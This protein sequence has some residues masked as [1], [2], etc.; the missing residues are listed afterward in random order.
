[1]LA[2]ELDAGDEVVVAAFGR[3]DAA[4]AVELCGARAAFADVRG[5]TYTVDPASV[6]AHVSSRTKAIVPTHLFGVSADVRPIAGLA[7]ARG[8][9]VVEDALDAF[10]ANDKGQRVGTFGD[11]A[12]FSLGPGTG[13]VVTN[14]PHLSV[15]L[16]SLRD[17][18]MEI[19]DARMQIT[20]PGMDARMTALHAAAAQALLSHASD[21]ADARIR[22]AKRYTE[23]L[24]RVPGVEPPSKPGGLRHVY[25]SYV[26]RV[27]G[28]QTRDKLIVDLWGEGVETAAAGRAI[29][30]EPY[31]RERYGLGEDDCPVAVQLARDALALP[32]WPGMDD[33][34]Q[35]AVCDA[36][37]R[38]H[39]C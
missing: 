27:A 31:Y 20:R 19:V 24:R 7:Q 26:V 18:G 10:G 21:A 3:P 25:E 17:H 23:H 16:R 38:C 28:D 37:E 30:V 2:L 39:A 34:T 6:E 13:F 32:L 22:L 35:D 29:H 33:A 11:M 12:C 1:M 15:R 5:E 4:H 9:A 14:D 8:L 36:I